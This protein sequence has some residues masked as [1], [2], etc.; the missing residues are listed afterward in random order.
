MKLVICKQDYSIQWDGVYQLALTHYPDIKNWEL[1][2]IVAFIAYEKYY[3]RNTELF[4][5]N[6]RIITKIN[7]FLKQSVVEFPFRPLSKIV[8]GTYD[9]HGQSVY[10]DFLSHTCTITSAIAI[11]KSQKLLATTKVFD[12][13][14]ADLV[15]SSRNAANDPCDYFDYI[16]FGW[17]NTSSG[18][19]LAMERHLGYSPSQT[20]LMEQFVPGVSFHFNYDTI[21]ATK[22]YVFD[23]YHP[24]KI[25]DEF[26]LNSLFAC[27]IPKHY[28]ALFEPVIPNALKHRCFYLEYDNDGYV[29]WSEKVYQ[30]LLS[31]QEKK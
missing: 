1:E 24:A 10:C 5:Q 4:C 27:I 18:Y 2:K 28:Q 23:G 9:T 26:S 20:E 11:L 13:S 19:R 3:G 15:K 6:S 7:I 31:L 16:M 8:A 30:H 17:S 29:K 21:T 14:S 12:L 22:G 25:K